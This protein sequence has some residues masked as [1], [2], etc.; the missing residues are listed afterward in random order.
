MLIRKP[1]DIPSSEITS[2]SSYKDFLSRRRFLRT[3]VSGAAVAGA[4]E[5]GAEA[6]GLGAW[7]PTARPSPASVAASSSAA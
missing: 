2:E 4:A 7:R 3:A 6:P 5:A 1:S